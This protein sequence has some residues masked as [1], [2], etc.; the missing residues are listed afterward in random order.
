MQFVLTTRKDPFVDR[1][2]L[3][4][5]KEYTQFFGINWKNEQSFI[6]IVKN[7]ESIDTIFGNKTEPWT[8]GWVRAKDVYLLSRENFE[9]ESS[10][11]YS[12]SFYTALIRHELVHAFFNA[13][14]LKN[15]P[16]WL[17]EGTAIY[18]SGQNTLKKNPSNLG[19]FLQYYHK[20]DSGVYA[21]SGFAIEALI[22]NFGKAKFLKFIAATKLSKKSFYASFRKIYGFELNYKN[23]NRIYKR[24][25]N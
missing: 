11:K 20:F 18:L 4:A 22:T 6:F 5:I 12:D 3:K 8:V 9:K 23:I 14:G 7:R 10:H 13:M 17:W 19:K 25:S 1:V 2:F 21:E 24:I 15:T 16:K